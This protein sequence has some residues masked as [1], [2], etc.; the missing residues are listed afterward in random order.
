METNISVLF[1]YL[2]LQEIVSVEGFA[3]LEIFIRPLGNRH[4]HFYPFNKLGVR[5]SN[6][7]EDKANGFNNDFDLSWIA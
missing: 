6:R 1:F 4:V 7:K 2:S 5:I 3:C